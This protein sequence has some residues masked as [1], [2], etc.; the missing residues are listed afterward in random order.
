MVLEFYYKVYTTE[1][2]SLNIIYT[3][4]NEFTKSFPKN[5]F[6]SDIRRDLKGLKT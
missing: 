4:V 5:M 1:T 3:L 2:C 6:L